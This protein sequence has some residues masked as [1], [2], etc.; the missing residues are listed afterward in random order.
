MDLPVRAIAGCCKTFCICRF[1]DKTFKDKAPGQES[2]PHYYVLS[3][4]EDK[5]I[6][7]LI[8]ITKQIQKREAYY[9]NS[10]YPRNIKSLVK[11][12]KSI[13]P[14]LTH[15]SVIECNQA[16][17]VNVVT[18]E[19]KIDPKYGFRLIPH[20]TISPTLKQDIKNAVRN[21]TLLSPHLKE[22]TEY[23]Q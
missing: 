14:C 11:V 4:T 6:Y 19:D 22:T 9:A 8:I 21:S 7:L 18:L 23:L 15:E 5:S 2:P 16:E 13:L 1:R 10:D 20:S 17:L 12:D 3:P